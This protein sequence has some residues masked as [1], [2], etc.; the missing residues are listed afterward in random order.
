MS[1]E[2]SRREYA[3]KIFHGAERYNCAQSVI[4][5]AYMQTPPPAKLLDE[6]KHNGGGRAQGGVCGA[7]HAALVIASEPH[8]NEIEADFLNQVGNIKCRDIRKDGT[9]PCRTCVGIA[10]ECVS[11]YLP[12]LP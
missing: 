4:A 7:L 10:T 2:T 1:E 12:A 6:M 5:A 8:R 9:Y 3:E 11:K